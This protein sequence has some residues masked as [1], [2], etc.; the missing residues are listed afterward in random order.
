MAIGATLTHWDIE[1]MGLLERA[2]IILISEN[3]DIF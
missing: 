3:T 2:E 1:Q